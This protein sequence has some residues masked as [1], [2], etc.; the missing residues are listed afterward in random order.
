MLQA[1]SCPS[2]SFCAAVDDRGNVATSTF[3]RNAKAL[4]ELAHIDGGIGG[5]AALGYSGGNRLPIMPGIN[6]IS[7]PTASFCAAVDAKRNVLT[8]RDPGGGAS[9][10]KSANIDGTNALGQV[11]CASPSLCV[12]V[13]FEGNLLASTSPSAGAGAWARA[14][15][16]NADGGGFYGLACP[17]ASLCVA[18]D[19]NWNVLTS[20]D[21]ADPRS[22]DTTG[23]ITPSRI[24]KLVPSSRF[25]QFGSSV[26]FGPENILSCPSTSFCA[27]TSYFSAQMFTSLDPGS[28]T[29][30]W[31]AGGLQ[32][33]TDGVTDVSCPTVTLCVGSTWSG[34]GVTSTQPAV[35]TTVW[36]TTIAPANVASCARPAP[37][38]SGISMT[39]MAQDAPSV[40]FTVSG[41]R[42]TT[43]LVGAL[44]DPFDYGTNTPD[45]LSVSSSESVVAKDVAV[46]SAGRPLKVSASSSPTLSP[47]VRALTVF[48]QPPEP[49]VTVHISSPALGAAD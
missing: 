22:W 16:D 2:V 32:H 29:S 11:A 36:T 31:T 23:H 7:C 4:W 14:K 6:D 34:S 18:V 15:I 45:G 24:V 47:G 19:A 48:W 30:Y 33:P 9:T 46:T 40:S 21:P 28:G 44:V 17:S 35:S 39:G 10:W 27:I 41:P 25:A 5:P 3:P 26:S 20:S 49:T 42:G 13:D 1:I 8:S 37:G 43:P 12:A 38:L